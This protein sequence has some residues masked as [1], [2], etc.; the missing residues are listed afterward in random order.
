MGQKSDLL[1]YQLTDGRTYKHSYR[2]GGRIIAQTG[3]PFSY[4]TFFI[5]YYRFSKLYN[6][7][8]PRKNA[9]FFMN[10]IRIRKLSDRHGREID[11]QTDR[12]TNQW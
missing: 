8:L 1:T 2:D 4:L 10:L 3:I 6:S 9:N 5:I 7:R 11:R 12:Q